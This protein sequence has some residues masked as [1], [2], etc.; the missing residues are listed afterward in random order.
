[1]RAVAL[2]SGGKDS[3]LAAHLA[4]E[5]GYELVY[6]LTVIPSDSESMMFHVPN[7]GLGTLVARAL[8]LEP[9][10]VRSGRDDE[11]DIEEM[12][13]VLDEIDV[14]ALVSGA[15]AS[16]Y[17]KERLDRLCEELGIEH[18]HPLWGM[19]PFEELEI[20]VKCGFEVVVIG[21]SAAGMDES[22]LGRRIDRDFIE[23]VRRLYEDYRVH[24]AGEGGEY[25]TLVLD[26]PLFERRIVLERVE[27]RW[28]GFSGELIV[29][30]ARLVPKRR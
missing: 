3:T 29:K 8:G 27:K 19:D 30:E 6:G 28:D 21:V 2:L 10:K 14:D 23:D 5:D 26:A 13:L 17:Q 4:V 24:P 9:L 22:W 7:A 15:I 16:R 12:A 18:V 20:L 1:M 25:E 11:A